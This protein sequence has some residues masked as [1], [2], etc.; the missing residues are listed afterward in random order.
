MPPRSDLRA[1]CSS[2]EPWPWPE[3]PR[4][5][6]ACR[7]CLPCVFRSPWDPP[8]PAGLELPS[9]DAQAPTVPSMHWPRCLDY[10]W[11]AFPEFRPR[12]PEAVILGAGSS[13]VDGRDVA[14]LNAPFMRAPAI[15]L[16]ALIPLSADA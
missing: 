12:R 2:G 13:R 3:I 14:H 5:D 8:V 1:W 9:T 11:L 4:P 7:R 6:L 15:F 10:Q 16:L